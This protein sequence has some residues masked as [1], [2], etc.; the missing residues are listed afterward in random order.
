MKRLAAIV[1]LALIAILGGC[2]AEQVRTGPKTADL[3]AERARLAEKVKK[4]KAS[5]QVA[6]ATQPEA[7]PQ[8][9]SVLEEGQAALEDQYTYDPKDKR[10]P[11]RSTFWARRSV[12]KAEVRGPLE[13]YELGQLAVVAVVWETNRP[14]AL[15]MDPTGESYV[16]REGSRVGKNDGLVIHIGDNLVLVKETYVDFAGEQ[17][18]KDVEMRIRRSQGG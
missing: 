15:V 5:A 12:E 3:A 16:I 10:D 8:G 4:K 11:F 17:S 14:R 7:N 1:A 6:K 2:E 18:T 13:Q 9:K